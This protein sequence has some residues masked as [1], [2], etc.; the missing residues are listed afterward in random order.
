MPI[1]S[2]RRPTAI[3]TAW[4]ARTLHVL[5]RGPISGGKAIGAM[6]LR[7]R[8]EGQKHMKQMIG[9][10][11]YNTNFP[12][13]AYMKFDREADEREWKWPAGGA[14]DRGE[15]RRPDGKA[16]ESLGEKLQKALDEESKRPSGNAMK[17]MHLRWAVYHH[18]VI[19]NLRGLDDLLRQGRIEDFVQQ[20]MGE[21]GMFR[22]K[23]DVKGGEGRQKLGPHFPAYTKEFKALLKEIK[24]EKAA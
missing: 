23:F 5:E 3:E 22:M 13:T 7:L 6:R 14:R 12:Y 9:E 19:E 16:P 10:L 21:K 17:I 24:T 2:D 4:I 15:E 8:E 20:C 18:W 1:I 11:K